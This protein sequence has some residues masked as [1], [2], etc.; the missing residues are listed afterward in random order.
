M[1]N[2]IEEDEEILNNI[3]AYMQENIN[4]GYHK[5]IY[6]DLGYEEKCADVINAI[7]HILQDYKRVLKENEYMHNELDKQQTTINKY[8]KENGKLQE[9]SL[10]VLERKL[11]IK[12]KSKR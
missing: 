11:Y 4:K 12:K 5:F 10:D 8:A 2:S 7:E 9:K 1:E 3:K 6:N